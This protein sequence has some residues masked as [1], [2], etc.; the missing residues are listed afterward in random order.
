MAGRVLTQESARLEFSQ[1]VW[2]G[3]VDLDCL[4]GCSHRTEAWRCERFE[5]EFEQWFAGRS[6]LASDAGKGK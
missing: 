5:R 4:P 3:C 1:R 2:A 6:L